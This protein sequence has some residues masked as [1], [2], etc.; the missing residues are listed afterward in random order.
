[1]YLPISRYSPGEQRQR[2]THQ[3]ALERY[4][5]LCRQ[6]IRILRGPAHQPLLPQ[7]PAVHFGEDSPKRDHISTLILVERYTPSLQQYHIVVQWRTR[8]IRVE[9]RLWISLVYSRSALEVQT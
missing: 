8:Y 2:K 9:S 7:A 5:P 4:Y 3:V 1:M 6:K